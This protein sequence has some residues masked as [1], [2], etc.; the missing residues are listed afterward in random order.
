MHRNVAAL[1]SALLLAR[2]IGFAAESISPEKSRKSD[3]DATLWY[4][5]RLLGLEGQAWSDVAAPFDR[6]PA[7]AEGKVR[8]AVWS[9]SRHSAGLCVRFTTD[10]P[11]I[12]AQWELTSANLAMPHMPATGVSGLDLYVKDD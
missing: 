2:T 3:K 1:I 7:K 11:Q 9:L 4:D 8:D 5:V 6:L 10:A 12:Q